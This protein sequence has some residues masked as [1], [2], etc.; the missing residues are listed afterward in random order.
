MQADMMLEGPRVLHLD[1]KAAEGD[2]SAGNKEETLI[3]HWA[4][5]ECRRPQSPPP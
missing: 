2:C 3:P 4:E 5:L 1:Q